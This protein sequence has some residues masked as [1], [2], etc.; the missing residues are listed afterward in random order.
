MRFDK[1]PLEFRLASYQTIAVDAGINQK[2]QLSTGFMKHLP[3]NSLT[4][5]AVW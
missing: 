2:A 1:V 3:L 4:I 5:K